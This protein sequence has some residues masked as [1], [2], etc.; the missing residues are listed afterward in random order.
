MKRA[1]QI[2]AAITIAGLGF[3]PT[4]QAQ[5]AARII[6]E[7]QAGTLPIKE[8][9]T[10]VLLPFAMEWDKHA[11]ATANAGKQPVAN[12]Y[13]SLAVPDGGRL[14][15]S[16]EALTKNDEAIEFYTNPK[17]IDAFNNAYQ[18]AV[19]DGSSIGMIPH[20]Q[21]MR[22]WIISRTVAVGPNAIAAYREGRA[23]PEWCLPPLIR[24]TPPRPAPEE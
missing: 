17:T 10:P 19:N 12:Q 3:V 16:I 2:L 14:T 9:S 21:A 6:E 13:K 24:C 15:A 8:T 20:E 5:D 11:T 1:R 7:L 23:S 4:V 18:K 22:Y